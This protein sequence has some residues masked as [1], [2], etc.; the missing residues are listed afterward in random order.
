MK[1]LVLGGT[2]FLGR[3]VVDAGLA[4][5]DEVTI[6]T[7]GQTNPDL[8]PDVEHLVG[9]RDGKL[10]ALVGRSWDGVVDTSGY[11]PRVVRQSAELLRD[12]VGRYAFVSSVSAYA[13]PSA[14]LTETSPLAPLED[15]LTE[16]VE[17]AY[18]A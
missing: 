14:P 18:G 12:A 9:D 2:K 3:H 6:F 11:V 5:G 13:D 1:L 7:R 15:P 4:R 8:Y 17:T 10:D 16:E